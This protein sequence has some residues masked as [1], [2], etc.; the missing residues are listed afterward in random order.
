MAFNRVTQFPACITLLDDFVHGGLSNAEVAAKVLIAS[1]VLK[2]SSRRREECD[3]QSFAV[4]WGHEVIGR[5]IGG[6]DEQKP[7]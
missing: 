6:L 3:Y 7:E 5:L 4:N 1:M 2:V